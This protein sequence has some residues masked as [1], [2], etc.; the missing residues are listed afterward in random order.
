MRG[1]IAEY[2]IIEPDKDKLPSRARRKVKSGDIVY[3][4]VR[5]NQ[6]HYGILLNPE[7]NVLVS[8][9]FAVVRAISDRVCP[10]LL[11][12]F[13]TQDK[14]TKS[15]QQI[16]E[17]SVSTYPSIKADDL[18]ALEMPTPTEGEAAELR[19]SLQ[20]LFKC[21]EVNRQENV[22]IAELRDALLP[23][24]MSG[25]VDVSRVD[26]MLPNNH[27]PAQSTATPHTVPN[28][29]KGKEQFPGRHHQYRFVPHAAPARCAPAQA[30]QGHD[31]SRIRACQDLASLG[32]G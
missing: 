19:D 18:G 16:A 24:L 2:Q 9:G 10:E 7:G 3:S 29:L 11:Y 21:I 31:E 26:I 14:L 12:L 27:L 28:P 15:L 20:L 4:T 23:K 25:E 30:A 1:D 8:T 13:L 22:R 32:P 5:P 6:K 17:Q